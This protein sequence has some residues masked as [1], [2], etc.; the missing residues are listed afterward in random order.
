MS[1]VTS[2]ALPKY[3]SV[4]NLTCY[5]FGSMCS[6]AFLARDRVTGKYYIVTVAHFSE[7]FFDGTNWSTHS[8]RLDSV[9]NVQL[10]SF[11]FKQLVL[12]MTYEYHID[13]G[14]NPADPDWASTDNL[15]HPAPC[16]LTG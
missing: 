15:W 4:S 8:V 7:R 12:H 5:A 13:N 10:R 2:T 6:V 16:V 3:N 9:Q 1:A 14:L 11:L